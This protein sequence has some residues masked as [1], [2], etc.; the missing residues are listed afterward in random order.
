MALRYA[1]VIVAV[2]QLSSYWVAKGILKKGKVMN[3]ELE[4]EEK[5]VVDIV[6]PSVV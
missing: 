2:L 3:E 5:N 1:I 6:K 4:L